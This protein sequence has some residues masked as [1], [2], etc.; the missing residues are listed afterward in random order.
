[1]D[2]EALVALV[3]PSLF[4]VTVGGVLILRPI[5][6]SALEATRRL[7][8]TLETMNDRLSLLGAEIP[9]TL[10]HVAGTLETMDGRLSLL[11]AGIPATLDHVAGTL[12]MMDA[13]LSLLEAEI[14][15]TLNHVEG[16]LEIMNARLSLLGERQ[17]FTER[18]HRG[19]IGPGED[20]ESP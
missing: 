1:M 6:G 2:W 13:R 15:A 7:R 14:P 4:I 20:E 16:T 10:D 17:G 8:E 18:A 19:G 12:E 9:A 11:G 3:V 5:A